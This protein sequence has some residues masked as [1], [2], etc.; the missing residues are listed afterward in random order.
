MRTY[1]LALLLPLYINNDNMVVISKGKEEVD[2]CQWLRFSTTTR[3]TERPRITTTRPTTT[4]RR[5]ATIASRRLAMR[6]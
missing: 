3:L 5:P 1:Y 6:Q 4:R 2:E